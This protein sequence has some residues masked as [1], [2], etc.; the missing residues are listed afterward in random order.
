LTTAARAPRSGGSQA[1]A[2]LTGVRSQHRERMIFLENR[3]TGVFEQV[4]N[5]WTGF[6]E[7]LPGCNVQERTLDEAR[8]SLKE[9]IQD[10]LQ[11]NR[12]IGAPRGTG[13]R[14]PPTVRAGKLKSRPEPV[15]ATNSGRARPGQRSVGG[16][17]RQWRLGEM[18]V[19]TER[20]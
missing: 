18:S 11:A 6:I 10:V 7:E 3:Y 9:A 14:G 20:T 1:D 12:E 8:A 5:W 2:A 15:H 16:C 4:D 19:T 13:S 17:T